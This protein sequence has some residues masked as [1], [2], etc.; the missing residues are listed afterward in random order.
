MEGIS[1]N[2]ISCSSNASL[3]NKRLIIIHESLFCASIV[4]CMSVCTLV[5]RMPETLQPTALSFGG[6][7]GHWVIATVHL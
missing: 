3:T 1:E 2:N 5:A 6:L 7:S 4:A